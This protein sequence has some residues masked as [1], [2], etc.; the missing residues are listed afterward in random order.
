[1]RISFALFNYCT[2]YKCSRRTSYLIKPK[3]YEDSDSDNGA[4]S[5]ASI[6]LKSSIKISIRNLEITRTA[7]AIGR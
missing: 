3:R 7:R 1:M 4:D 6:D 2:I 5:A